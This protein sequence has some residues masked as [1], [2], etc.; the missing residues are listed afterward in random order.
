[1]VALAVSDHMSEKTRDL[2]MSHRDNNKIVPTLSLEP[3]VMP[4]V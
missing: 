4:I 1:M 2:G 3:M